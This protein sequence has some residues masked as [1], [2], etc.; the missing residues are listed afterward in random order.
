MKKKNILKV[1]GLVLALPLVLAGCAT[2]GDVI[3]PATKK[4]IYFEDVTYFGG[5]AAKIGDYLYYGNTYISV[6]DS[7]FNYNNAASEGYLGRLNLTSGI[8]ADGRAPQGNLEKVN[9]KLA[10]YDN[11]YMFAYQNYLYFTSANTHKTSDLKNDYSRVSMFRVKF[12]GDGMSELFT[13]KYDTQSFIKTTV[14]SDGN[15]YIVTYA[16]TDSTEADRT[17]T[18]DISVMKIGDNLGSREVV[19]QKV[20]SAVVD[21]NKDSADKN[22]IYAKA[23]EKGQ[24]T[25]EVFSLD[26]ASKQTTKLETRAGSSTSLIAKVDDQLFYSYNYRTSGNE[27]YKTNLKS[28]DGV[29]GSETD[30]FYAYTSISNVYHVAANDPVFDGYV[31]VGSSSLMYQNSRTGSIVRLLDSSEFSNI[32]FVDGNYIY[33]SN[34]TSIG[35][36]SFKPN[37]S[38]EYKKQTLVTMDNIISGKYAYID[39]Y[40]YFYSKYIPTEELNEKG[41]V[42]NYETDESIYMYR[43]QAGDSEDIQQYQLISKNKKMKVIEE[44][45]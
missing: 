3:D 21:T 20:T 4:S 29:I 39:G 31:F 17:D 30:K 13:T 33:F 34:S 32:L 27:V 42:I 36:I 6:S 24:S 12:N 45:S 9:D 44:N 28:F 38:G 35:R 7:S 43:I 18:Y 8:T 40:I 25:T 22:I 10:G 1:C 37:T 14:G 16:K 19:A 2:V 5:S 26:I 11:Q 15:A 41:E 23:S